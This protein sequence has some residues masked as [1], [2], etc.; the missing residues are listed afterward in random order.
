MRGRVILQNVEMV[1]YEVTPH[2]LF[3]NVKDRSG[4]IY[5]GVAIR[6]SEMEINT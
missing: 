2:L 4:K 6:Y 1:S 3:I 5:E